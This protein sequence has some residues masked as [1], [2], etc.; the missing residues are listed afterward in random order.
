MKKIGLVTIVDYKNY[1]NRL[2]NYAAQQVLRTIGCEVTTIVNKPANKVDGKVNKKFVDR[3]KGK[4]F[5]DLVRIVMNR[6]NRNKHQKAF[7]KKVKAFKNFSSMNINESDFI[8]SVD[9]IP[10]NLG[11]NFDYFVVGSDQVWNPIYRK[12]SGIDFLEFAPQKK[13][14]AYAPSFGIAEIPDEYIEKYTKWLSE[15]NCLSVREDAGS[16]IIKNL[17]NR[18]ASVLVDPTVMLTKDEWLKIAKPHKLKPSN[19]FLLTYFLGE[20]PKEVKQLIG[21]LSR[22][23]KLEVVNLGSYE[24]LERYAADP[25]EFIDYI[26]TSDIF[27]TD[28]FHGAVF[29]IIL[30]KQFIVFNRVSKVPS[31]NS[32]IDTLLTKFKFLDRKWEAVKNSEDYF[33]ADFLHTGPIFEKEKSKAYE[34]L[35]DALYIEEVR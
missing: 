24:Q 32:R 1:G 22:E 5:S 35:R 27:L 14:V 6:I 7:N 3:L 18:E 20:I 10:E 29:S 11:N 16:E 21:K 33:G 23:Y 15:F 2:Q 26:N 30:E 8:I 13:R 34:Y 12:G 25:S 19:Q 17:T 28:S 4:S 31:M 9:L